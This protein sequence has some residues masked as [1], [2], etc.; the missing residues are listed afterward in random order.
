MSKIVIGFQMKHFFL[1][2]KTIGIDGWLI[3]FY[4]E[5]GQSFAYH[6]DWRQ[7]TLKTR[8][9]KKRSNFLIQNLLKDHYKFNGTKNFSW[10]TIIQNTM[11]VIKKN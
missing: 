8:I 7:F 2:I 11:Q 6:N 3:I 9:V 4:V 10:N 5:I 1:E